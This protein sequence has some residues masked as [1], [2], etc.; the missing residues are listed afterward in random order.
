MSKA[1]KRNVLKHGANAPAVM[2]WS[3]KSEDYEALRAELYLEYTPSGGTEEHLVQTL[4]DLLW[5]K[6]RL[7]CYEQIKM[8]KQLNEIRRKN[9]NSHTIE[10]LR[11]FSE[12]FEEA[13]SVEEVEA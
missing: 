13:G 4:L 12:T 6:R 2:L 5:R 11:A 10:N 8:Q 1:K 9:E 3:E 7:D